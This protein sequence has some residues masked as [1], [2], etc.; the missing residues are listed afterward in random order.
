MSDPNDPATW[1]VSGERLR[2][3]MLAFMDRGFRTFQARRV[4]GKPKPNDPEFDPFW[5]EVRELRIAVGKWF[6]SVHA[7]FGSSVLDSA[8]S[9][10]DIASG[11]RTSLDMWWR[12]TGPPTAPKCAGSDELVE[13]MNAA[14][15]LLQTVPEPSGSAESPVN[16]AQPAT[17]IFQ[18][19]TALLIMA[20]DPAK[21]ELED[22]LNAY[23]EVCEN[24]GITARRADDIEHQDVITEVILDAIRK[25]EFLIADLT[26]ERPNVYYE[27]GYAHAIGKR[28]I[29]FRTEG[30]RL[31]FDLALYNVPAYK[32]VT[33]LKQSLTARLE[34]LTGRKPKKR[35]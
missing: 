18:P 8:Q 28:P 4:D 26:G 14:L 6:N 9:L 2:D 3:E 1:I 30:T 35:K 19:N 33:G 23:R 17:V 20:I 13:A 27:V 10:N 21:P 25:S 16:V 29:L 24:F 31:H 11:V 15:D 12:P 5:K 7:R 32:N 22:V 34:A